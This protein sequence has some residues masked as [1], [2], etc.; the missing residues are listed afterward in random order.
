METG[1][2]RFRNIVSRI[3]M[4]SGLRAV[5]MTTV[6]LCNENTFQRKTIIK[7]DK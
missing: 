7:S 4:D 5:V 3:F 1:K 6:R 2:T